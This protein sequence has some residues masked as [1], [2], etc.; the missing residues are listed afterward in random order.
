MAA[1]GV[2]TGALGVK[3][4]AASAAP[5]VNAE[6]LGVS[7]EAPPPGVNGAA[8][9]VKAGALVASLAG[10]NERGSVA[11]V[12]AAD[13]WLGCEAALAGVT[14]PSAKELDDA[15]PPSSSAASA[16]SDAPVEGI[17]WPSLGEPGGVGYGR[18]EG[19]RAVCELAGGKWWGWHGFRGRESSALTTKEGAAAFSTGEP[20]PC[21]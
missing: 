12:V 10:V 8:L 17:T 16:E 11:G 19:E 3:T 4:G 13:P 9:G 20:P 6:L 15:E 14:G 5:G 1:L 7:I 2:N 18:R 21:D